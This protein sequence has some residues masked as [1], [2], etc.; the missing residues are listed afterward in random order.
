MV[1]EDSLFVHQV[2][3]ENMK[4]ARI[5]T[6]QPLHSREKVVILGIVVRNYDYPSAACQQFLEDLG[7]TD[8]SGRPTGNKCSELARTVVNKIEIGNPQGRDPYA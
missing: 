4:E 1:G 5:Q 3:S 6:S 7:E 2:F 8:R